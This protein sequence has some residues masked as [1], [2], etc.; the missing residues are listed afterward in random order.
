MECDHSGARSPF[1]INHAHAS[2]F[3]CVR[4]LLALEDHL[5]SDP[6]VACCHKHLTK[7]SMFLHEASGLDGGK[8]SDAELGDVVE[9]MRAALVADGWSVLQPLREI[10]RGLSRE[11]GHG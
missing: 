3:K 11:I 6:C 5:E 1:P 4:E 9:R 2:R 8:R 10:R 7:A